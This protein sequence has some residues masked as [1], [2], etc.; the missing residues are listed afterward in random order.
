MKSTLRGADVVARTLAHAG[1]ERLFS[2]S[3]NHIMSIYDATLDTGIDIVHVRHEAAAVHMADAWA[4]LSGEAG[5]A[6]LTGGPGHA[7]GVSALF[8]ALSSESPIV[9]ISG[10]AP[11]SQLGSGAFQEMRQ[12]DIAEPLTKASWV[13]S[14]LA[15][16]GD[17]IGRA[18]RIAVSGRPGPVHISV[19]D[20]LLDAV[21]DTEAFPLPPA[22]AFKRVPQPLP[23]SLAK[24][25]MDIL[26]AAKRP[27]ILTGP[28][29]ATRA[30]GDMVNTLQDA[31]GV[32]VVTLESP[33]GFNEPCLGAFAEVLATADCVL[34]LGK[35]PDFTLGFLK[36]P[37]VDKSCRL[38]QIDPDET[39]LQRMNA[40]APAFEHLP[41]QFRADAVSATEALVAQAASRHSGAAWRDEVAQA[42]HYRPAEWETARGAHQ[43]SL[44][45]VEVCAAIQPLLDAHPDAVLICDGGEFSQWAQACLQ[46]GHRVINGPAGAIGAGL[47]FAMAAR[48]AYPDSPVISIMGDG[49]IGFHLAEFDTAVRHDLPFVA[50]VG[51][52]ACWNAEYQIQLRKYGPERTVGCEL[53]S[54]RYDRVAEVLGGHGEYVTNAGALADALRKANASGKPACVNIAV[55]RTPAPVIRRQ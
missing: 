55:D 10:H 46:A 1:I 42:I 23:A 11:L 31:T 19:P 21:I 17:A 45:A 38:L 44:H 5:I 53:L 20:D 49:S 8:T 28:F 35:Q 29:A 6:L 7:N 2:L 41:V 33:R 24:E 16:L 30:A 12:A 50:V 14:E 37:I 18:L 40:A 4:R 13:V 22:D 3:G 47:P 52:D 26:G 9:L 36:P 51:N 43:N 25:F 15:T 27:L 39:A 32:P 54:T 34:L 48:L